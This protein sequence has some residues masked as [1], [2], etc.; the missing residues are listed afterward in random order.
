[1]SAGTAHRNSSAFFAALQAEAQAKI[2]SAL[3]GGGG[4][5]GGAGG[6]EDAA[7]RPAKKAKLTSS[8]AAARGGGG[9]GRGRLTGVSKTQ[10]ERAHAHTSCHNGWARREA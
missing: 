2:A 6:G 5:K 3:G 8:K 1:M 10:L 7:G 4:S 9:R